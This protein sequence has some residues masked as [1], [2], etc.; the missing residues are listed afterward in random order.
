MN[1]EGKDM[2]RDREAPGS[3]PGPPDHL[4]QYEN[5]PR[6]GSRGSAESIARTTLERRRGT[7]EVLAPK[8]E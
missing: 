2:V 6:E 1:G 5:G 8:A 4:L 3:N 7:G